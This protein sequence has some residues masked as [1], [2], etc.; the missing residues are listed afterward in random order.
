M[1]ILIDGYKSPQNRTKELNESIRNMK[2]DSNVREKIEKEYRRENPFVSV[3]TMNSGIF[4]KL[5]EHFR[6]LKFS[7]SP[8]RAVKFLIKFIDFIHSN[9]L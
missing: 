5:D 7:T 2:K 4:K 9:Y 8:K 6:T 1:L 3:E